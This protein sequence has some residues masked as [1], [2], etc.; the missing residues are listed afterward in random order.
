MMDNEIAFETP[1]AA[2]KTAQSMLEDGHYVVLIS[3]EEELWILNYEY[4][5]LC[6]RNDVVFM[7][8]EEFETEYF[9]RSDDE[10]DDDGDDTEIVNSVNSWK[11]V[12]YKDGWHEE[13][14]D[15]E[16]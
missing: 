2:F 9:S 13:S 6:N 11:Q 16:Q 7:S 3:R 15:G 14:N 8:R 10:D 12:L 1:E 5:D 4:S